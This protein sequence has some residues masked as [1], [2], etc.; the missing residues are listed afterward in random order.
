MFDLYKKHGFYVLN[1][2]TK[3]ALLIIFYFKNIM[4][5]LNVQ[6][7]L[8]LHISTKFALLNISYFKNIM[9]D[10]YQP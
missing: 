2:S 9:F 5:Y 10:W 1:T 4:F 3:F 6:H 7:G 8:Y